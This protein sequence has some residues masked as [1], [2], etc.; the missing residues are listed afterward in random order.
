MSSEREG[1]IRE[2]T[3]AYQE[4]HSSSTAVPRP[5]RLYLDLNMPEARDI[6]NYIESNSIRYRYIPTRWAAPRVSCGQRNII[7]RKA[8]LTFLEELVSGQR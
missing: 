1:G 8:V 2:M 6:L 3:V 5:I 4:P 7:G